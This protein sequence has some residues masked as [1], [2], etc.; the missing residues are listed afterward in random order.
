MYDVFSKVVE[1]KCT[2]VEKEYYKIPSIIT[3]NLPDTIFNYNIQPIFHKCSLTLLFYSQP[4]T[5]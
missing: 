1:I 5:Q 2:A 3:K 4:N